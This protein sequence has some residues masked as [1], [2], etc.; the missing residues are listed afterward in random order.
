MNL[1]NKEFTLL[2]KEQTFGS[3][4]I[5]V[6]ERLGVKCAVSDFAILLGG[7][8][9]DDDYVDDDSSLKGRTSFWYLSSYDTYG[10]IYEIDP[11]GC[12]GLNFDGSSYSGIRPVL[13]YSNISDISS[14]LV[15]GRSGLLEVEYGE[16]I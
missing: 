7:Y 3:D 9:V 8:V 14:N 2:S 6:I 12:L 11:Y 1:N 4:K 16:Y 15:M 5:D 10:D 13:P